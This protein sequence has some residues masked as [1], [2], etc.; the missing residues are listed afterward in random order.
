MALAGFLIFLAGFALLMIQLYSQ[1]EDNPPPPRPV[2]WI[3][4]TGGL[5]VA[6]AWVWALFTSLSLLREARAKEAK[7]EL[8]PPLSQ[9]T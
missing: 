5:V 8:P 3:M 6:M 4:A 7:G 1:M 2:G 9:S